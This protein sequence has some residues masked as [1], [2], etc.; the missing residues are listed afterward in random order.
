MITAHPF[1]SPIV[2]GSLTGDLTVT[3][4]RHLAVDRLSRAPSDQINPTS[5]I[6][7]LRSCLATIPSTQNRVTGEESSRNF[8]GRRF[9]SSWTAFPP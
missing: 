1:P 2:P 9:S 5:I 3:S 6:P 8:T 7:Y 4:A